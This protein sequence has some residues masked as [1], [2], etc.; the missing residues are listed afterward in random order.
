MSDP[1]ALLAEIRSRTDIATPGPWFRQY[2][3][4]V[5]PILNAQDGDPE[6]QQVAKTAVGFFLSR[7]DQK[8]ADASF[9]AHAREDIPLLVS[10]L[11]SVLEYCDTYIGEDPH[12]EDGR[13]DPILVGLK[14]ATQ[15]IQKRLETLSG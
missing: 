15:D 12:L 1:R 6:Y 7:D 8:I 11:E 4:V 3:V 13:L 9:I 10:M 2:D 5:K 14:M